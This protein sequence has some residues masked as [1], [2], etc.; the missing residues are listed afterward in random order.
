MRSFLILCLAIFG[1]CGC[2]DEANTNAIT[3]GTNYTQTQKKAAESIDVESYTEV[4]DVFLPTNTIKG[5]GKPY[6]LVFSA[7]G[8]V[9]C[10]RLK[11]LIRD[12]AD[13]KAFLKDNYAP[14]YINVSYSKKHAVEFMGESVTTADLAQKYSIKP[15]PTLIFLSHNGKE[16]FSY[17]GFMPKEKFMRALE[18]FR[19]SA[20]EQ[21]DTQT[22]KQVFQKYLES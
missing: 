17:P 6:F 9:Y 8:C 11:N 2:Q 19:D 12:N 13:I 14:Y 4:S 22:I 20:L 18:F 21:K 10:D 7:N 5:S 1:L 16:L 15:T 3:S